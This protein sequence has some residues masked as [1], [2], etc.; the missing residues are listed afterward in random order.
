MKFISA[1]DTLTLRHEL[2]IFFNLRYPS[3]SLFFGNFSIVYINNYLY[4]IKCIILFNQSGI[5]YLK[6]K[7]KWKD[8]VW[9]QKDSETIIYANYIYFNQMYKFSIIFTLFENYSEIHQSN[10]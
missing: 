4:M 9:K 7:K 5:Y 8:Y 10:I 6:K 3:I 2:D 1:L